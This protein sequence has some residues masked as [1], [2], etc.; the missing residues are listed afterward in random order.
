MHSKSKPSNNSSQFRR[1]L[2]IGIWNY[3]DGGEAG[4]VAGD[5][6]GDPV[7]IV[8]DAVAGEQGGARRPQHQLAAPEVPR[9]RQAPPEVGNQTARGSAK[10][11]WTQR[12]IRVWGEREREGFLPAGVGEVGDEEGAAEAGGG[13]GRGRRVGDAKLRR[14]PEESLHLR[15]RRRRRKHQPASW[16]LR[17]YGNLNYLAG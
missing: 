1:Q 7:V 5:G 16:G 4:E 15:R 13:G 2:D 12:Q 14:P 11:R 10:R 6:G 3:L 8:H 17:F 9:R